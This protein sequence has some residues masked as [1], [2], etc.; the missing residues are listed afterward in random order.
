[1]ICVARDN[2]SLLPSRP[3]QIASEL[4]GRLQE[5]ILRVDDGCKPAA[6]EAV[7]SRVL[8]IDHPDKA[9]DVGLLRLSENGAG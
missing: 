1:M 8:G 7:H 2:R 3:P 6:E 4:L 9:R 5:C